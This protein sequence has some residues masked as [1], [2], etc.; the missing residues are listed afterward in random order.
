M[1]LHEMAILQS[2]FH[3]VDAHTH[4]EHVSPSKIIQNRNEK[5]ITQLNNPYKTM[6]TP[7]LITPLRH[8][9]ERAESQG[10]QTPVASC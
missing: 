4:T 10:S 7:P 5:S 8:T 6:C 1:L 3:W 9:S 2:I